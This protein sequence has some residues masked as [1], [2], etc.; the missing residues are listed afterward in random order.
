[1]R[2]FGFCWYA[3]LRWCTSSRLRISPYYE[4][5]S[6][7]LI[8]FGTCDG[9]FGLQLA[10]GIVFPCPQRPYVLKLK[11]CSVI[12][13]K[14]IRGELRPLLVCCMLL[15]KQH[16]S[17]ILFAHIRGGLSKSSKRIGCALKNYNARRL[18]AFISDMRDAVYILSKPLHARR[19]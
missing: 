15:E 17:T 16:A 10:Q 6:I 14:R 19:Y 11:R 1:M 3:F 8:L 13:G 2:L 5:S 7:K 18:C 4:M 12:K 9:R